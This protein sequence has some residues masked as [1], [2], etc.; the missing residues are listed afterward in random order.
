MSQ[1]QDDLR[2]PWYLDFTKL[3]IGAGIIGVA[4]LLW[5]ANGQPG[6]PPKDGDYACLLEKSYQNYQRAERTGHSHIF[7]PREDKY[8]VTLAGGSLTDARVYP[9]NAA[10]GEWGAASNYSFGSKDSPTS[11]T[12]IIDGVPVGCFLSE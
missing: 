6:I 3:F 7:D 9:G 8:S 10:L 11:F 2:L 12:A 1:R 4:L 5:L